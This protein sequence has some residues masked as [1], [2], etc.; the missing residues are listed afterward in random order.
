MGPAAYAPWK[1]LMSDTPQLQL[2]PT[3][4]A[5]N[6]RAGPGTRYQQVGLLTDGS[7]RY[8]VLGR[9]DTGVAGAAGTWWQI[10][11]RDSLTGWVRGDCVQ[12][13]PVGNIPLAWQPYTATLRTGSLAL[14]FPP[15]RLYAITNLFDDPRTRHLYAGLGG[16]HNGIDWAMGKGEPVHAMAKGRVSKIQTGMPEDDRSTGLGNYVVV[17]SWGFR[18]VYGHLTTVEVPVGTGVSQGTLLGTAGRTGHAFGAHLHV[19]LKPDYLTEVPSH[20]TV[21]AGAVDFQ[22]YLPADCYPWAEVAALLSQY[23]DLVGTARQRTGEEIDRFL[24]G[25]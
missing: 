2:L 22:P 10:R 12:R 13:H 6:V 14:P 11:Y 25:R 15:N 23:G 16:S 17:Q 5:L 7:Q 24:A 1:I 9:Y 21:V 18:L 19:H 20:D 3:T 4:S 8:S